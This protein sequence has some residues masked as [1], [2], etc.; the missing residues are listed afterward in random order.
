MAPAPKKA[1]KGKQIG[2]I[3]VWMLAAGVAAAVA[4]GLYLRHRASAAASSPTSASTPADTSGGSGSGA[5]TPA[6]LTPVSDLAS[7]LSGLTGVLGAGG[8]GF[9][10]SAGGDSSAAAASAAPTSADPVLTPSFAAQAP[11]AA[12]TMQQFTTADLAAYQDPGLAQ[13]YADLPAAT[14]TALFPLGAPIT[15]GTL[16]AINVHTS[17]PPQEIPSAPVITETII[18]PAR[19]A[20]PVAKAPA[21][22]TAANIEQHRSTIKGA[23]PR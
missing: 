16:P 23:T 13:H 8:F 14:Q 2:G 18:A 3:P 1:A 17:P 11:V 6:D 4:V 22:V 20:A 7:A 19:T 9:G 15:S 12:P 10:S 5:A 21:K